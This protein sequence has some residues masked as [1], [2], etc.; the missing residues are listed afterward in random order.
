MPNSFFGRKEELEILLNAWKKACEGQTQ[1][2]LIG[3]EPTIGKTALCNAFYNHLTHDPFLDPDG[4]WPDNLPDTELK[5]ASFRTNKP[6]EA[7][8]K[9]AN[10]VPKYLWLSTGC[11]PRDPSEQGYNSGWLQPWLD[12]P[13][14]LEG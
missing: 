8:D 14:G 6:P 1:V 13:K 2:V 7:L 11:T 5:S 9:W 4:Y 12:V 3:G 10:L